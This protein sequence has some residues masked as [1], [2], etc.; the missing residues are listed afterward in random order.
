MLD[1][2]HKLNNLSYEL[3]FLVKYRSKS[4]KIFSFAKI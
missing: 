3:Q 4:T 1:N 2:F